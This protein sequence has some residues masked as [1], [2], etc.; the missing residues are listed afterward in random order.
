MKSFDKII[1]VK[2]TYNTNETFDKQYYH[3]T[4]TTYNDYIEKSNYKTYGHLYKKHPYK[5]Y[6]LQWLL[7]IPTYFLLRSLSK[8]F[9][10][11]LNRNKT[12]KAITRCIIF[13]IEFLLAWIIGKILDNIINII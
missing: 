3:V 10:K 12:I 11:D 7:T 1:R 2:D 9:N 8:F 5:W 13:I 6:E 4:L